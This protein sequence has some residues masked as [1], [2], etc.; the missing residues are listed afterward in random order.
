MPEQIQH[1]QTATDEPADLG[2]VGLNVFPGMNPD[3]FDF[4]TKDARVL[5]LTTNAGGGIQRELL[6]NLDKL[7]QRGVAVFA[8]PE[9][10]DEFSEREKGKGIVHFNGQPQVDAQAIGVTYL[11]KAG[12]LDIPEVYEAVR[13]AMDEGFK[14]TAL[15]D[16][17]RTEFAYAPEDRPLEPNAAIH[18]QQLDERL[19]AEGLGGVYRSDLD[20]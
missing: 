15:A 19:K 1:E 4:S 13:M 2:I 18:M 16:R 11:E 20:G 12:S 10:K 7:A 17:I 14:G 9:H 8:L 5:I 6:P 3:I